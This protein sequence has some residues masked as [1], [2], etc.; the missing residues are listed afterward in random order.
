[1][2]LRN[3][4]TG[5]IEA[6]RHGPA[7]AAVSAGTHEHVNLADGPDGEDDADAAADLDG[8]TKDELLAEAERRGVTVQSSDTKAKIVEVIRAAEAV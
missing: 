2:Q 3:K 6:M 5:E 4:S 1:M 8:M 7:V